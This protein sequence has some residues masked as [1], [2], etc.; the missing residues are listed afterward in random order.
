M[1][2]FLAQRCA[3]LLRKVVR[4]GCGA[5]LITKPENVYYL[6]G[7]TGEDSWLVLSAR[8]RILVT[9]SRFAEEAARSCPGW[10]AHIRTRGMAD[11]T[12]E[13]LKAVGALVAFESADLSVAMHE[14]LSKRLGRRV[15]FVGK[16]GLVEQLRLVKDAR[17][18]VAIKAAVRVAEQSMK[19]TLADLDGCASEESFAATLDHHMR[20]H[21]ASGSAFE[22]IAAAEPNSSL[23]HA[24]PSDKRLC[25]S[26]TLLVDWGARLRRYNSDL[27]RVVAWGKV[28]P[29]ICAI[30]PVVNAAQKAAI[31]VIRPGVSAAR[32]DAV[33]RKVISDAGY[34]DFFG[35]GLGHGV[36]LEV[37]E[38]PSLSPSSKIRLKEGMVVTVEPGIYLPAVGGVRV[39]D[40][41]LVTGKGCE[42]LT[43]ISRRPGTLGRMAGSSSQ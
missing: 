35:H 26:T 1:S 9:D 4:A 37:H 5:I 21:G 19:A 31:A 6:S 13:I 42:V 24:K 22:T 32:V 40:M 43:H 25:D 14:A 29:Q 16:L 2:E 38:G 20:G 30:L 18:I 11:T 28:T 41:V 3:A 8:K 27:T 15:R 10:Q 7:F 23:P 34:G 33:A 36:G 39:E 12:A 17:E